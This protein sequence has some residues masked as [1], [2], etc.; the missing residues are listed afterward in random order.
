M[1]S[2][3][4]I[5]GFAIWPDLPRTQSLNHAIKTLSMVCTVPQTHLHAD[6]WRPLFRP[7]WGGPCN[8]IHV[9]FQLCI[10]HNMYI[11]TA[12]WVVEPSGLPWFQVSSGSSLQPWH[13][14]PSNA[15]QG[16]PWALQVWQSSDYSSTSCANSLINY[17]SIGLYAKL[18]VLNS[19]CICYVSLS[20]KLNIWLRF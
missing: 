8:L 16:Y 5:I 11:H 6:L 15:S 18:K 17:N 7:Y 19:E 13:W 10:C 1:G 12:V 9:N 4:A 20:Q 14:V 3:I 2:T